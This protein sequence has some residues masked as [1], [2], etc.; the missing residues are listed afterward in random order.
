MLSAA[1]RAVFFVSDSTG[2]TAETLGNAL[3]ANFP[4]AHFDRHT[5]PFV[6]TVTPVSTVAAALQSATTPEAAP[7]V[8]ATVK[9]AGIRALIAGSAAVVIDLLAGHLTEL[10]AALDTPAEQRSGQYHGLGDLERY[11]ARMRAVEFAIEHDDGQ[12]GRALDTADVIIVAPSRCGKTPTTMYLALHYGLLVANYPLTDD[13]FPTDGLPRIVAPHADR[14]FG[15][16]TTALR[17]SQVRH[18]RR[19]NSTYASLAQCTLEIRR[20]EDLYRR[21]RIPFLSSATRSVEEMSAVILQSMK[22][23]DRPHERPTP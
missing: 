20:A 21:N 22:L 11:F 19:P 10:E 15:L 2:I 1:T 6:G 13:D 4:A 14:C 3:L 16:T 8:F 18:E 7:I 12:S 17:L 23:R 5:I 9:D